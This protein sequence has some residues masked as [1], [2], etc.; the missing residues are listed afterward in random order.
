MNEAAV[1][2]QENQ[3]QSFYEKVK[4]ATDCTEF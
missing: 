3:V 1:D 4:K 2:L